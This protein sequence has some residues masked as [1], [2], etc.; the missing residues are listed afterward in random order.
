MGGGFGVGSFGVDFG[1]EDRGLGGEGGGELF[2]DRSE[3]LAVC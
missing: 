1:D 2:P 3:G